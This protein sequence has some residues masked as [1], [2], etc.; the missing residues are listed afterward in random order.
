MAIPDSFL[1]KLA[2]RLGVPSKYYRPFT[3][4]MNAWQPWEGGHT[5]NTA[6]HNYL[7]TTLDMGGNA[8]INSVGVRAY[9]SEDEGVN[10]TAATLLNGRYANLLKSFQTGDY[11]NVAGLGADVRTWTSGSATGGSNFANT[12]DGGAPAASG[13]AGGSTMTQPTG[14]TGR[15]YGDPELDAQYEQ[16]RQT[17]LRA[18]QDWIAAGR[19]QEGPLFDA[20][21]NSFMDVDDFTSVF[22]HPKSQASGI[23][24]AQQEF[25]NRITLGDFEEEKAQGAF[26]RWYD[27]YKAAQS[28]A[29]NDLTHAESSNAAIAAME[30]AR[31]KSQTPG[32]LPRPTNAGFLVRGYEDVLDSYLGKHGIGR[33]PPGTGGTDGTPPG[34]GGTGGTDGTPPAE[35][36]T[37]PYSLVDWFTNPSGAAA[38]PQA[39]AGSFSPG[40]PWAEGGLQGGAMR[41][42]LQTNAGSGGDDGSIRDLLGNTLNK[43]PQVVPY[44]RGWQAGS[45]V[46]SGAKAGAKKAKKWW[47][48]HFAEGGTNIPGGPGWVGER[49]PEIMEI[50]GFGSKFV[51]QGGPEQIQIPEGANIVPLDEAFYFHQVQQAARQGPGQDEGRRMRETAARASDPQLQEKVLASIQKALAAGAAAN[52]PYT[53]MLGDD[54]PAG[55]RDPWEAWRPL[56]GVVTSAAMQ[57]AQPAGKGA[58]RG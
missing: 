30:D 35:E 26:S 40:N 23:D 10:A 17:A 13:Q 12:L 27:R 42:F 22:G 39:Q 44:T 29:V 25:E 16:L 46:R 47:Q 55:V 33:T 15:H 58:R 53:P 4:F 32:L 36:E 45:A 2:A 3:E 11:G 8:A 21:Q 19:P 56:T 31:A 41:P 7:N 50:P 20:Y 24:P 14:S 49:G 52:P 48:R 18:M 28:E 9:R 1:K 5:N 37:G 43:I 38:K 54:W 6:T 51:G 34:T 57:A